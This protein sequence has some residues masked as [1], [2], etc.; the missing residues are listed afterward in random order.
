MPDLSEVNDRTLSAGSDSITHGV[1]SGKGGHDPKGRDEQK[2]FGALAGPPHL[3]EAL[4]K[5]D[6]DIP[7]R[8]EPQLRGGS[9]ASGSSK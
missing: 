2:G 1:G 4:A 6:A 8:D 3:T 7:D 5:G 9:G